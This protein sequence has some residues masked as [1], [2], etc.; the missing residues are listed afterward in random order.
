[1]RV[2]ADLIID[3]K[4]GMIIMNRMKKIIAMLLAVMLMVPA[5][6]GNAA[7]SP[8]KVNIAGASAS[9]KATTYNKLVQK[10]KLTVK[11]NGKTLVEGTHFTV[12][13]QTW[14][15]AGTYKVT[16]KGKGTFA[17]TKTVTYTINRA[18]QKIS[19]VSNKTYSLKKVRKKTYKFNLKAKS[20]AKTKITYSKSSTPKSLRKY[21]SVSKKGTV[22]LSKKAKKGTYK[23]KLTAKASPTNYKAASKIFTIKVK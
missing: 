4:G 2:A 3:I 22:T 7:A 18:A 10:P 16:I 20:T 9:A 14:Q 17:G 13:K 19:T 5:V 15:S 1:M 12:V 23:I 21:I 6:V 8:Q 11:Y